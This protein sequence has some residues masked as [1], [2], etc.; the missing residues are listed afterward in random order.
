MKKRLSL[1]AQML[2]LV[3]SLRT[4]TSI[5]LI[6]CALPFSALAATPADAEA[7]A[8][9]LRIVPAAAGKFVVDTSLP[10]QD[11]KDTF[12][13]SDTEDGKI[14]IKGNNGVSVAAGFN[15]YLKNRAN[16]HVSWCGDQLAIP[17]PLPKVGEAVTVIC[18][19][20]RRIY[21]NYCTLSYSAAW[22]DWARWQRE[23]DFMAMQGIN[24]PL[25]VVGLEA[26]WYH[27]LLKLGFTD[28]EART[29]LCGPA[30]FAW[31]WMTNI[32]GHAGPLPKSWIDQSTILG[33]KIIDRQLALGMTPIQQGFTGHVPRLAKEK[34]PTANI[35]F[36]KDW[37]GFPGAAQ[38]D[39]LDSLFEKFG[40]TFLDEQQRLFGSSHL[41]GCDPFHE[42]SPPVP[43]DEYLVKVGQEINRL[44]TTHDPKGIIVMQS[45]SIRKP[46]AT[47]I[48]KD[49]LLVVDLGGK[50][51]TLTENFWGYDFATGRL[52]NF[53]GRI[54]LHGDIR[55]LAS[56]PFAS[57]AQSIPNCVGGGLFMEGIINNPAYWTLAFDLM[58]ESEPVDPGAWLHSYAR[59]R[60]GAES[61][62][63][64]K[65]WDILL[66]TAYK[67]ETDGTEAS[68]MICARP[69]IRPKKSG[70]NAALLIPYPPAELLEAWTLL[71]KDA[72]KLKSSDAYRFDVAD[73]GRQ[74]LSNYSQILNPRIAA[75]WEKKDFA[76]FDKACA[77]FDQLLLDVDTLIRPR[78]E[79]SF[80][81]WVADARAHGTTD[82]EKNLYEKNARALVTVW[83]PI[84][85][86]DPVIQ[87]YGWR[88][89][90]GL[91][92]DYYL[93]RWQMHH[94]MLRKH[95]VDKTQYAEN[96]LKMPHGREAFRANAFFSKLAD[97]ELNWVNTPGK[98]D[99]PLTGGDEIA[100][101]RQFH[102]KYAKAIQSAKTVTVDRAARFGSTVGRWTASS[103]GNQQPQAVTYDITGSLN[104]EGAYEVLF[105]GVRD[106]GRLTIS[107]VEML[108]N[109]RPISTDS[110]ESYAGGDHA[111]VSYTV[112][113]AEHA[114]GT[115]YALRVTAQSD[116]S[117]NAT[118]TIYIKKKEIPK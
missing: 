75:A 77:D 44:V 105:R 6:A 24:T 21:F 39:P 2:A 64:N 33:R 79:Y 12:S 113:L 22:W 18:P 34:F 65:A 40:K 82:E 3:A 49:S 61:E 67:G 76:A 107:N 11:N 117:T 51:Q 78:P 43:G 38:L 109:G 30:F 57:M 50:K 73:I 55:K 88:E 17:N 62:N 71:L 99:S 86:L 66:N 47:A 8:L 69:A 94:A 9:I 45:W 42:G 108:E 92:K 15:W 32:E 101:A 90:S 63:A 72:E 91:I 14:L 4:F 81:K 7:Q 98:I 95:L 37:C 19:L 16:C 84:A 25:S 93:P 111:R 5:A 60:Y 83:G 110:R 36:K 28:L 112:K 114:F 23:I 20:Q 87:D 96:N 80:A 13:V 54:N 31:Q 26:V 35:A 58:W 104:G 100:L 68:S 10:R 116:G 59:R 41:Y 46:I 97:W 103:Y 70:P 89:W 74:V 27:T 48:P 106:A 85:D 115:R 1:T 29:F 102:Q 53:G 56:N 118:G 52:N